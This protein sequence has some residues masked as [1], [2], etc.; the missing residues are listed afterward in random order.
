M[1][2]STLP[3]LLS[4][5]L[6]PEDNNLFKHIS[7]LWDYKLGKISSSFITLEIASYIFMCLFWGHIQ[8]DLGISPS[9]EY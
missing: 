5:V 8:Q 9:S 4:L 3:A 2:A 6:T 1:Q 7:L